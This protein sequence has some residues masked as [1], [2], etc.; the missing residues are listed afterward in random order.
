MAAE[1]P[2]G[3][4]HNPSAWRDR[5]PLVALAVAGMGVASY[6]AAYQLGILPG[7]WDPFFGA[8]SVRVLH[9]ALARYLPIPDAALGAGGYATEALV[10]LLGG[11][12]R[13]RTQPWLVVL[14]GLIVV[15]LGA[16]S[17]GLVITQGVV[18]HA[19]CTLCLLSA[20]ISIVI[21][22]PALREVLAALQYL[23]R[24]AVAGA[25]AWSAFWGRPAAGTAARVAGP[26][27][28]RT[29]RGARGWPSL[30]ALALGIW[31]MAAPAVLGYGGGLAAANDRVVGPLV[32][33]CGWVS[34]WGVGRP[35]RW[36]YGALGIWLLIAPS[37]LSYGPVPTVNSIVVGVLLAVL[38]WGGAPARDRLGGGWGALLDDGLG[39]GAP[40]GA[41]PDPRAER[42]P[43]RPQ[44]RRPS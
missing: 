18:F 24:V 4:R 26:R 5:L 36:A 28:P 6:L 1:V 2:P 8:D 32:A 13:W 30:V 33:A 16:T 12:A 21:L 31:L 11:R 19:W 34:L 7:V 37:L 27:A 40:D 15:A 14:Y 41:T 39:A 43:G 44:E 29:A 9:S 25:P 42:A 23:N 35:L 10:G 17:V 22:G 20:T 3:W 38:A